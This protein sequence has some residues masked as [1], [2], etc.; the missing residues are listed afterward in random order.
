MSVRC[1]RAA[2]YQAAL[3]AIAP[4]FDALPVPGSAQADHFDLRALVI[5]DYEACHYPIDPPDVPD[6]L[7]AEMIER[8][9]SLPDL[10]SIVGGEAD[11]V[12]I[13]ERRQ[14]LTLPQLWRLRADWNLPP[15]ALLRLYALAPSQAAE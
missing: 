8:G 10:A 11:A 15:D 12:A 9:I 2:D 3:A 14:Y 4:Y 7:R 5:G 6:L 13:L 1:G